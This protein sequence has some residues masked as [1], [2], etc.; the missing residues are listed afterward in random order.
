MR[1]LHFTATRLLPL[2]LVV[3]L[4]AASPS[5]AQESHTVRIENGVVFLDGRQVPADQL[6]SSLR[7]SELNLRLEFTGPTRFHVGGIEYGVKDGQIQEMPPDE[8]GLVVFFSGDQGHFVEVPQPSGTV[9][10][11][12]LDGPF[13]R[14][15]GTY[16]QVLDEQADQFEALGE[17]LSSRQVEGDAAMANR[18]REE[19]E[20]AA[21]MV[22]AF[23]RVEVQTYLQ[24][25]QNRDRTLYDQLMREQ[26]MEVATTQLAG[27]IFTATDPEARRSLTESL[28]QQLYE[29]FELKQQNRRDE[30]AEL[31]QQ[32]RELREQLAAR[33]ANREAI[34]AR[35]LESLIGNPHR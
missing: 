20:Q 9:R 16:L 29:I 30:I 18:L 12:R 10:R 8:D 28:R 13:D 14:T 23:P 27:R 17:Q 32:L 24:G 26:R 33:E 7:P 3:A 31:E 25:I 4:A 6:P 15:I 2:A 35:R 1:A 34:V 5:A 22:R 11:F 19:A 21:I